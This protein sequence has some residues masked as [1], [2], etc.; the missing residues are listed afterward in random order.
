MQFVLGRAQML[1]CLSAVTRHIVMVGSPCPI[2][3][4]H[5]LENMVVGTFQIGPI[6]YS[7]GQRDAG[8]E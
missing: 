5:G 7:L 1:F 3:I 8:G 4:F 2:Q 6:M